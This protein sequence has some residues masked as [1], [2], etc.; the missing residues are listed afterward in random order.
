M[1]DITSRMGITSRT[2]ITRGMGITGLFVVPGGKGA[3]WSPVTTRITGPPNI[4]TIDR[5]A[6]ATGEFGS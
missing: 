1:M 6:M 5:I 2:H 3:G 4:I